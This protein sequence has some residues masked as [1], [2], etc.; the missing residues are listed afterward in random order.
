MKN[1]ISKILVLAI[2]IIP[3]ICLAQ[4]VN[5]SNLKDNHP[6]IVNIN[7]GWDYGAVVGVGYGQKLKTKLPIVLNLEYSQPL[8]KNVFDDFKTKLGG[9]AEVISIDN[10]SASVKAYSIFRRYENDLVTLTNFGSEFS[11]N[12]GY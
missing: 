9:Q 1:L 7:T 6:H 8:G 12:V 3:N 11:T 10:F 4:Q 5:W 2:V